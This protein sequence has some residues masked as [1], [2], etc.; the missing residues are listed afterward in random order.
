MNNQFDRLVQLAGLTLKA[1]RLVQWN[2]R[3]GVAMV[4]QRRREIGVYE[5]D[6]REIVADNLPRGHV[7]RTRTK[8][9]HKTFG[10]ASVS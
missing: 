5:I 3:V 6:W 10:R 1:L 7:R 8:G 4:N 2:Q 9:F